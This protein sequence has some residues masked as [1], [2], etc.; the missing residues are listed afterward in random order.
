MFYVKPAFSDRRIVRNEVV[1][2]KVRLSISGLI[3]RRVEI[4]KYKRNVF[5]IEM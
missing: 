2:K 4:A 1:K 3:I 5:W